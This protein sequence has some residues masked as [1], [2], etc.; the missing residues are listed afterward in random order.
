MV[1]RLETFNVVGVAGQWNRWV[2]GAEGIS[3]CCKHYLVFVFIIIYVIVY[4]CSLGNH[5]LRTFYRAFYFSV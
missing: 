1:L 2:A 3:K 5:C 4:F